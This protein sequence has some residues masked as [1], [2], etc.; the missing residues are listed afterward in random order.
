[1]T[2]ALTFFFFT[3]LTVICRGTHRGPCAG[4]R[5]CFVTIRDESRRRKKRRQSKAALCP[6]FIL[7]AP[8]A[9]HASASV[10]RGG[11]RECTVSQ[12]GGLIV[13]V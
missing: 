7:H 6:G 2:P 9:D 10:D 8:G 12:V 3:Y 5:D 13:L 4:A 11:N 1:M